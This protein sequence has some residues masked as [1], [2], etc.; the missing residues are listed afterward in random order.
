MCNVALS[1]VM[2]KIFLN[3]PI[4]IIA[5][6]ALMIFISLSK[7]HASVASSVNH[8]NRLYKQDKLD[9]AIK[10]YQQASDRNPH[11]PVVQYDLG[12]A[13]Y[14]KG[15]YDKAMGYLQQSVQNKSVIIK[16]NAEYNLGNTLYRS[17][18]KKENTNIEEAIQS[19]Q[20][21]LGHYGQ[22]LRVDPKD[23]D[24]QFN[25]DIVK[26]EIERLKQK[27]QQQQN[28][29][30]HGNKQEKQQ[31]NQRRQRSQASQA[32]NQ[33]EK[34]AQQQKELDRKQAENLLE[35]YQESQEPKKLLNY[36]PKK[37]NTR[38]VLKDW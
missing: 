12:T 18:L 1:V 34:E 38:P 13:F 11:A 6:L 10:I 17:G 31:Q 23:E 33:Q 7:S 2:K 20:E 22:T 28:Q 29:Q 26:R 4:G 5:A 37:I 8:A 32:K 30:S 21:A 24:A 25:E 36:M 9:E 27:K 3:L 19:L 14:K 35:D 16:K 15:D